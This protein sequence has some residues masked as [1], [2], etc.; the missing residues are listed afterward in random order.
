M[1][2]YI[3]DGQTWKRCVYTHCAGVLSHCCGVARA[4]RGFLFTIWRY[5]KCTGALTHP[6][7]SYVCLIERKTS[8]CICSAFGSSYTTRRGGKLHIYNEQQTR[9]SSGLFGATYNTH[10]APHTE[11]HLFW[12]KFA[13]ILCFLCAVFAKP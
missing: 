2:C 8:V 6:A 11:P 7:R 13:H 10:N 9:V 4:A 1:L 5:A 12:R 3:Y